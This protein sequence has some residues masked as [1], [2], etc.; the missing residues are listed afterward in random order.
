MGFSTINIHCNLISGVR[1]NC[2]DTDI[3]YTLTLTEPSGYLINIISTDILY[4]NVKKDRTEYF[5][6]RIQTEQSMEDHL[7]SVVMC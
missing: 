5:E 7:I 3:L 4:Q 2:K 6:I 1:D